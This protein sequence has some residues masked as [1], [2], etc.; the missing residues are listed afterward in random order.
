M[1]LFSLIIAI[2]FIVIVPNEDKVNQSSGVM[3]FILRWAHSLCWIFLSL[4]FLL[5]V[6]KNQKINIFAEKFI[7]IGG[8]A[9]ILYFI[10]FIFKAL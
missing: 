5:R 9:Y 3:Y 10:T 2:I 7:I 8:I 4:S 1:S 6:A